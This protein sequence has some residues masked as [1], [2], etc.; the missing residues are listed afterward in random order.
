MFFILCNGQFVS[1]KGFN[2]SKMW[3]LNVCFI[4]INEAIVLIYYYLGGVILEIISMVK[5]WLDD[6]GVGFINIVYV[7]IGGDLSQFV[8]KI[9]YFVV[10]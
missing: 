7:I 1:V 6:Y 8:G 9:F 2:M 10:L 4:D 5:I 3:L